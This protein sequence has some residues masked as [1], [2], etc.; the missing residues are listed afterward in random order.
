MW[1][2][3]SLS[4]APTI[5]QFMQS[6][7]NV[8]LATTPTA[9]ITVTVTSGTP[10]AVLL[11]KTGTTAAT[12]LNGTT[13]TFTNVTTTSVG[14]I[15]VQGQSLGAGASGSSIITA[16]ASAGYANGTGT[17]SVMPTGFVFN[18]SQ[19]SFTT[20]TLS[21]PT[22]LTL[23]P[24]IL[25]AG[26]AYSSG[27]TLT[28]GIG[29]FNVPVAIPVANAGIGTVTSPVVFNGGDTSDTTSFQP[30]GAGTTPISITGQP[31]LFSTP[32]KY[33]S[34][35]AT[36]TAPTITVGS[37][38]IGQF[39]QGT[40]S[41][42]LQTA[43]KTPITVIVTSGTPGAVLLS[44]TG[45]TA[46]TALNGTSLTFNNVTSTS[47][48]T[49]YVQGQSLGAGATGSST[50][51]VTAP[52][53]TNGTGTVSV[54]PTGFVFNPSQPTFTTTTLSN[55]TN[56]T[57][58][59]AILNPSTLAYAGGATLTPGIGPFNVPVAIPVANAGIGT[60]TSP[61]VFNGG[62][63]SDITSFQPGG[64]GTTPINITGQPTD[65]S[66]P[67]NYQSVTATVTAPTI[68][69][70]SA[71]IGQ[72]MQS[73]ISV[74]L[75]TAPTTPITVMVTSGTPGTVLLSKTGTTA[76]TALNGTTLT[77]N[78]VT[79][80]S[81]GTIYVQGQAWPGA[82]VRPEAPPSP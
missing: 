9:P 18:P 43:P 79:S 30:V 73:S 38:T 12:A 50:I 81:V 32:T 19:P 77:F 54:M 56:V 72:I 48:G 66:T 22:S 62:D 71:T 17:V 63:S 25:T 49:I 55:P 57:L 82:Q 14:T 24:A 47:V 70:G 75:Q 2:A 61:V 29:P 5:G 53:Y 33:Q 28:P 60:V 59:P 11:S 20:T 3:P 21:N 15:Y 76:A 4:A 78:N 45:T 35:T 74:S 44:M 41:V 68:T 46:A 7:I 16:M 42:S 58:Q 65:F 37:A 52:G 34:V 64:A 69:V 13:L 27:G 36:V 26:L 67:S 23:Q 31:A 51:T 39:M 1:V 80:T 40:I 6:S 10:G 8:S